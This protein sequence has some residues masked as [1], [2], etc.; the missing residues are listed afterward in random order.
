MVLWA[1]TIPLEGRDLVGS[2]KSTKEAFDAAKPIPGIQ[3]MSGTTAPP[4]GDITPFNIV[5]LAAAFSPSVLLCVLF[6]FFFLTLLAPHSAAGENMIH[7]IPVSATDVKVFFM[8]AFSVK[9]PAALSLVLEEG[10]LSNPEMVDFSRAGWTTEWVWSLRPGPVRSLCLLNLACWES[11]DDL[12][13]SATTDISK[14]K[15]DRGNE[16]WFSEGIIGE[17]KTEPQYYIGWASDLFLNLDLI[18]AKRLSFYYYYFFKL[19]LAHP[20]YVGIFLIIIKKK[21]TSHQ[22]FNNRRE[23]NHGPSPK[24]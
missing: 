4:R 13:V 2:I 3:H 23:S 19:L 16:L 14:L 18:L 21:L 6:F 10:E 11:W 15:D 20:F 1:L 9:R 7:P 22:K 17:K 5:V 24:I 8:L 12:I